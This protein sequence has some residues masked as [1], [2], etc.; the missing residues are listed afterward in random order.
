MQRK[1]HNKYTKLDARS[2][3]LDR[4]KKKNIYE[5]KMQNRHDSNK[6]RTNML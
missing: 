3:I 6:G 2:K 5:E 4:D 1:A